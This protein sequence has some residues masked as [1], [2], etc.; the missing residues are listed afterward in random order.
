MPTPILAAALIACAALAIAGTVMQ[1]RSNQ[2]RA[3][4]DAA[5][6][7]A[8]RHRLETTGEH[9][10]IVTHPDPPPRPPSMIVDTDELDAA[11]ILW[12]G[13]PTVEHHPDPPPFYRF[14]PSSSPMLLPPLVHGPGEENT[15]SSVVA[16]PPGRWRTPTD[17]IELERQAVADARVSAHVDAA[18]RAHM[19]NQ[20]PATV[21]EALEDGPLSLNQIVWRSGRDRAEV[22]RELV[23][24][25]T[26]APGARSVDFAEFTPGNPIFR[27]VAPELPAGS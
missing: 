27:L 9:M 23:D 14:T 18:W 10:A 24:H 4:A 25:L 7:A 13:L 5:D 2:A 17:T 26:A 22:Y 8:A 6:L 21:L 12:A 1:H 20:R 16:P 3:A 19:L 15:R 11:R